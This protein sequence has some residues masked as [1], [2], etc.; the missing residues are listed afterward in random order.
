VKTPRRER[1]RPRIGS[2][3]PVIA[4][5]S[6]GRERR[7]ASPDSQQKRR[8]GGQGDMPRPLRAALHLQKK[9][10]LANLVEE[11]LGPVADQ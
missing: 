3:V 7:A 10:A 4:A 11:G 8:E 2:S 9:L 1:Q 5:A 6:P